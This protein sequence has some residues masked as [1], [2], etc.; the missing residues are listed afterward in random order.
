MNEETPPSTW[1]SVKF[2]KTIEDP[3]RLKEKKKKKRKHMFHRK[4]RATDR[5]KLLHSG[6]ECYKSMG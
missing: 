4:M 1:Y 5:V 6:P 2:P 3:K